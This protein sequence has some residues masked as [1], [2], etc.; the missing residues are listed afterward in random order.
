MKVEQF[1]FELPESSIAQV[2]VEPRDS[3]KMLHADKS[4]VLGDYIVRELPDFLNSG[5]VLV[6]NDTKVIP[7]RLFG[8]RATGGK[9][10]C[11][12]HLQKSL[13]SWVCFAKPAKKCK[14]GDILTFN[15]DFSA[16][17]ID[18]DGGEL[19]LQFN[20][21]GANLITALH[22]Y[23]QMPLPPYI[24]RNEDHNENN[25]DKQRY[26][27]VFANE[28]GAVAAPTAGLHL[29][30]ELLNQIKDKGVQIVKI[31]LH[32]GA[33]TFLPVVVDDTNDHKMHAEIGI[34]T[35]D[36][37]DI[38]N[39]AKQ[40]GGRVVAVGTTALRL[41]ESASDDGGVLNE[42]SDET[43]LFITPGYEFKI[44]DCLMTNYH[45]PKSTLF[46][47]VSAFL[48]ADTMMNVY[49][50]AIDNDY[51]FYSYGDSSFLERKTNDS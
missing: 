7:A 4:G 38:I 23:G 14:T 44:V 13:D 46:M 8:V 5:D 35:K 47:L 43:R 25:N 29:T 1:N 26:Q 49:K 33:G 20:K 12:L 11:T 50:Y 22:D 48:G 18:R 10:E 17:V 16:T 39:T 3:A 27:T 45:L 34:I 21:S 24:K 28:E 2:A 32:V 30:D 41:L 15:D 42:F 6:L 31:T 40:N 9:V 51:R 37:A 19:T 36:E